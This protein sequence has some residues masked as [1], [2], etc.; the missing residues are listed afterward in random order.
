[1]ASFSVRHSCNSR[2]RH[3]VII[4]RL[5]V[6]LLLHLCLLPLLALPELQ[7]LILRGRDG[8]L[9]R[10]ENR[11]QNKDRLF[12]DATSL[13]SLSRYFVELTLGNHSGVKTFTKRHFLLFSPMAGHAEGSR[14]H[15][16]VLGG[17]GCLVAEDLGLL[18]VD[19]L[20]V[21]SSV[22]LLLTSKVSKP[23]DVFSV[24]GEGVSL[25]LLH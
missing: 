25:I 9:R 7:L 16:W 10:H 12:D 21:L 6:N 4:L 13:G 19:M 14:V 3:H 11:L 18:L 20:A 5:S 15:E 17:V 2:L 8:H 24:R 1:M 22:S 23:I